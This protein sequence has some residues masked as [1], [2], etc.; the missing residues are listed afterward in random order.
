MVYMNKSKHNSLLIGL[1]DQT[2]NRGDRSNTFVT[3][4]LNYYI[5]NNNSIQ[6]SIEA[7]AIIHDSLNDEIL[8]I[9][10]SKVH[11]NYDKHTDDLDTII[12]TILKQFHNYFDSPN[13]IFI[14]SSIKKAL[15]NKNKDRVVTS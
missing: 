5:N 6:P 10:T 12:S 7:K 2:F 13:D 11:E 3:S 15:L 8:K 14:A 9:L 1:C 4:N